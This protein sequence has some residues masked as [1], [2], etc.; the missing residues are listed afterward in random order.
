[1]R[2]LWRASR[3]VLLGKQQLPAPWHPTK[4][5]RW[6]GIALILRLLV[7]GLVVLKP[8]GYNTFSVFLFDSRSYFAPIEDLLRTGQ[9][10]GVA[11]IEGR[12]PGYG[13]FYAPLYLL[14]FGKSKIAWMLMSWLQV[15]V[16]AFSTWALAWLAWRFTRSQQVFLWV[17]LVYGVNVFV[18]GFDVFLLTESL[19]ASMLILTL[20]AWQRARELPSGR[21][22]NQWLLLAGVLGTWVGFLKVPFLIVPV[23]LAAVMLLHR[24][25]LRVRA[26][27]AVLLLIVLVFAEG[28]WAVRNRISFGRW[29]LT[30]S[31]DIYDEPCREIFPL[32]QA[33]GLETN[34][35]N[36]RSDMAWLHGYSNLNPPPSSPPPM[37]E[38]LP[39][40]AYLFVGP[41][42]RDSLQRLRTIACTACWN[43]SLRKTPTGLAARSQLR[44]MNNQWT[45]TLRSEAP[46]GYYLLAPLRLLR[47]YVDQ[48]GMYHVQWGRSFNNLSIWQQV[49]RCMYL[50]YYVMAMLLGL[51][52][53]FW[54]LRYG[55]DKWLWLVIGSLMLFGLLSYPLIARATELRYLVPV[56]PLFVWSAVVGIWSWR[57]RA[58]EQAAPPA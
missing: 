1:M 50:P 37:P 35:W 36:P 20:A 31:Y 34:Q 38:V 17:L 4:W 27:Q 21:A 14:A 33:A 41:Y 55:H 53:I 57:H 39:Y 40:P 2:E 48:N 3:L 54:G 22:Q 47:E 43:D 24:N 45:A 8:V 7:L 6:F 28:A 42:N 18:T 30:Q 15:L 29:I 32:F 19:A 11:L 25:P 23:V 51:L 46:V 44:R 5:H 52:G 9:Y 58:V 12:M 16:G 13:L 56:L 49:L 10:T 26:L